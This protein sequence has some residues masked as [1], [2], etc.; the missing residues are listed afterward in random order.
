MTN[1]IILCVLLISNVA[2]SF[3][4]YR[5]YL[6]MKD[7][8]I[9]LSE[10][11]SNNFRTPLNKISL[12]NSSIPNISVTTIPL[13]HMK[14]NYFIA[15]NNYNKAK[16]LIKSGNSSNPYLGFGDLLLS[17][18]Y[19]NEKKL[20]SSLHF[21]LEAINKLPNNGAH[22]QNF[23]KVVG[24]NYN[25]SEKIFEKYSSY[26]E[27]V[28]WLGYINH[29]INNPKK[30][31]SELLNLTQYALENFNSQIDNFKKLEN[32]LKLGEDPNNFQ[33]IVNE[34]LSYFNK[35]DFAKAISKFREASNLNTNDYSVFENLG[36][37]Y[38]MNGNY[39]EALENIN[40]VIEKFSPNNGKAEMIKGLIL[41]AIGDNILACD[42]FDEAIKLGNINS[43][44]Y[45]RQFCD[46]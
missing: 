15:F 34:G 33:R 2:I 25:L 3:V 22:I 28:L 10:F 35:S 42:F 7:Q 17:R 16:S 9:L 41:V 18:I 46:I 13:D 19:F 38:Y 11:N 32:Y 39:Q 20:D 26:N 14:A 31:K 8:M 30:S 12:M 24:E 5:A 6:S 36:I 27:P 40:I 23:Y 43:E 21:A 45:Q 29:S 44:K 1:R 4:T 37:A